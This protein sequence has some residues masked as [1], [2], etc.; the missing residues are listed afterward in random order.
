MEIGA[1]SARTPRKV[2]DDPPATPTKFESKT[3]GPQRTMAPVSRAGCAATTTAHGAAGPM[4]E[5]LPDEIS[6]GEKNT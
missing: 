1:R 3:A 2:V 5:L 6:K 4:E